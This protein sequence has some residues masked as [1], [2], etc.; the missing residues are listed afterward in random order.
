VEQLGRPVPRGLLYGCYS[1]YYAEGLSNG[2]VPYLDHPVEYP[3]LTGWMMEASAWL[4]HWV[5]DVD[6]RGQ[7]FYYVTVVM[8]ATAW[9]LACWRPGTRWDPSVVGPR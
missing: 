1:L 2:K 5:G 7:D 8:L 3:V 4:V 9:W 6:A